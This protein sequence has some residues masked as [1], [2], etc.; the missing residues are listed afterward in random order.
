MLT[1]IGVFLCLFSALAFV[2]A[3]LVYSGGLGGVSLLTSEIGLWQLPLIMLL[4]GGIFFIAGF[5]V[6]TKANSGND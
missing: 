2:A 5:F 4:F 3:F 6:L 1:I